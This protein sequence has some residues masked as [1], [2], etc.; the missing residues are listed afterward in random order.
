MIAVDLPGFGETP[1]FD[2]P[3]VPARMLSLADAL[4]AE[5]DALGIERPALV[6]HSMGGW[7]SLELARRGRA[8]RVIALGPVGGSVPEE[9]AQSNHVLRRSRL[10]TRLV[11]P[12]A[13]LLLRPRW[14]RRLAFEGAVGDPG[15]VGYEE[16]LRAIRWMAASTGFPKVVDDVAGG[17][18][19]IE[20][21]GPRFAEISCPVLIVHGTE[22]RVVSPK[23]GRR[24][25]DAIPRAELMEVPGGGHSEILDHPERLQD[26]LLQSLG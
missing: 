12:V 22:D 20:D 15:Q 2:D 18:D 17:G 6:G 11:R 25:A 5:L 7:I 23:G 24:L 21:N 14:A 26:L 13:P 8:S 1:W 9:S 10:L 19:Q 3:S 4:Q 16:G